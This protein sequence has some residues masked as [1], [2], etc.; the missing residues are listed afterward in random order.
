MSVTAGR[1]GQ[2]ERLSRLEG[3]ELEGETWWRAQEVCG[4]LGADPREALRK[5]PSAYKRRVLRYVP[6]Y[7]SRR[8]GY[9]SR[10]GVEVLA[11]RYGREPRRALMA[12]LK[13]PDD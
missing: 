5:V 7:R 12:A 13:Y 10:A 11:I 4:A 2:S 9:L 1:A 6:G 3:R 8:E